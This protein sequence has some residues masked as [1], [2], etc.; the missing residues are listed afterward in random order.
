M[1]RKK[2]GG[3][4]FSLL[5]VLLYYVFVFVMRMSL[6][7][8]LLVSVL[9]SLFRVWLREGDGFSVKSF[10]R[11]LL[12]VFGGFLLLFFLFHF[13]GRWGLLGVVVVVV[14]VMVYRLVRYWSMFRGLVRAGKELIKERT[15]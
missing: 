6:W 5:L 2:F 13:F 9:F 4:F 3:L 1:F 14:G 11:V 8:L 10:F 7:E 12:G 15:K